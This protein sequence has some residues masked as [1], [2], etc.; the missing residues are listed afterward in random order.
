[1]HRCDGDRTAGHLWRQPDGRT[2]RTATRSFGQTHPCAV[3]GMEADMPPLSCQSPAALHF[4]PYFYPQ[5]IVRARR[6]A[7]PRARGDKATRAYGLA[8]VLPGL[9]VGVLC[10]V[11]R[12]P[13][14][15][16][17]AQLQRFV[18]LPCAAILYLEYISHVLLSLRQGLAA[19]PG[20]AWNGTGS[21]GE[22]DPVERGARG[23]S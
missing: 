7:A 15:G 20:P 23:S 3:S 12:W 14:H 22:C 10:R 11:F 19:G 13:R 9:I 17:D 21:W 4:I 5:Q 8:V 18:S 16:S 1:M 2:P 6:A